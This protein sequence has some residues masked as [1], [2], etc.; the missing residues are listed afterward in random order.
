MSESGNDRVR[1]RAMSGIVVP[2]RQALGI[3]LENGYD[4]IINHLIAKDVDSF[5]DAD[6]LINHV[7]NLKS[8]VDLYVEN[9]YLSD[10]YY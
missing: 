7:R 10:S 8:Q 5:I 2:S 9:S 4:T 3:D 1:T 6:S